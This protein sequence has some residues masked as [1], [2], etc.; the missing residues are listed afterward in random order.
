MV[1]ST[2]PGL[3][4]IAQVS[5][6]VSLSASS[7]NKVERSLSQ[8]KETDTKKLGNFGDFGHLGSSQ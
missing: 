3:P 5:L 8:T 7:I 2:K 4:V 6:C 1:L